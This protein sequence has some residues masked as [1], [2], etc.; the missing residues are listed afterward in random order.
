LSISVSAC[1]PLAV[2]AT[3]LRRRSAGSVRYAMTDAIDI[4]HVLHNRANLGR[5]VTTP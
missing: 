2:L 3:I 1:S 4:H 5:V